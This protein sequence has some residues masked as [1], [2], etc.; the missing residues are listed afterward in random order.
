MWRKR[1]SLKDQKTRRKWNTVLEVQTVRITQ[2][3]RRITRVYSEPECRDEE[4]EEYK[5][6]EENDDGGGG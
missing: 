4:Q 1:K 2:G 6:G 3:S 5:R